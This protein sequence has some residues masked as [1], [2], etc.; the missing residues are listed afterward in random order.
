MKYTAAPF[1]E[2]WKD[3]IFTVPAR[4]IDKYIR[5]TS[6]YQLKALLF[7]PRNNGQADGL[8]IAEALGTDKESIADIMEFWC[9]EGILAADG[10]I[11][12][13]SPV[14]E[15]ETAKKSKIAKKASPPRL[16]RVDI[17]NQL[18]SNKT[19][20]QLINQAQLV[21]ARPLTDGETEV[22]INMVNY[23][24][25]PAE[26]I[27]MILEYFRAETQKG[28]RLSFSYIESMARDWAEEGIETVEDAD[29]KLKKIEQGNRYWN[30]VC[31]IAGIK[32]KRPTDKQREIV[33]VWFKSF[34][35]AMITLAADI[36]KRAED[37]APSVNYMD[38]ILKKWK[39]LDIFTVEKALEYQSSLNQ[40]SSTTGDRL[41]SKPTYDLD[42]AM[43]KA[44]EIRDIF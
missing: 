38:K 36:M 8:E 1:G 32:L 22:I 24:G 29:C 35:I 25:L 5:L 12:R 3:G 37:V 20:T 18:K 27:L 41:Q 28:F 40:N 26:V 34:D 44:L 9:D 33:S 7:V 39:K 10:E 2:I 30:E 4:L 19:L 17:A 21:L 16:S 15:K 23:Y 43:K 14:A 11:S 13:V 31:A 42:E 6:E